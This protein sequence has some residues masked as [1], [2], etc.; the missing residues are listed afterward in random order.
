MLLPSKNS[1]YVFSDDNLRKTYQNDEIW[2][3]AE[4]KLH[5]VK[6]SLEPQNTTSKPK[7]SLSRDFSE[8]SGSDNETLDPNPTR[9]YLPKE[10]I[11]Y[12]LLMEYWLKLEKY[13]DFI[14][15]KFESGKQQEKLI[16]KQKRERYCI[17]FGVLV[18]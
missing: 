10:K 18:G 13:V 9:P 7:R 16:K 12:E 6:F 4:R 5:K 17:S 15:S 1:K 11:S 8:G 14:E 3:E 2:L